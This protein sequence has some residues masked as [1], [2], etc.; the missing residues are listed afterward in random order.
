MA[1][2]SHDVQLELSPLH[3]LHRANQCATGMFHLLAVEH[4]LTARQFE[5]LIAISQN[6]GLSQTDLVE[7]TGIDRST[8]AD[9]TQRLLRKGLLQRRRSRHDARAYAV[10]L[11]DEGKR[12]VKSAEPIALDVDARLLSTLTPQRAEDFLE[13][14]NTI[15]K[16]LNSGVLL[17]S[18]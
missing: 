15:V 18:T 17:R 12:V 6:E 5:V 7:K 4:G 13:S 9:M 16:T 11:T 14:L 3:L 2:D 8:M 1:F 10:K